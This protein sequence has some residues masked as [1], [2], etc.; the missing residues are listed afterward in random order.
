MKKNYIAFNDDAFVTQLKT[1]KATAP[2]YTADLDLT[3]AELAGQAADC[4]AFEYNVTAQS[5][6]RNAALQSTAFKNSSRMGID[7]GAVA[8]PVASVLPT[9]VPSV[10]AG[11]EARFRALV[12]RIK[13]HPN[14]TQAIGEA[15]GIEG[16]LVSSPD[17]T[18]LAP[19]IT[20]TATGSAV[21]VGW[22]FGG[23]GSFL[24]LCEIEVDRADGKG[25]VM[26]TFDSTP[27]YTDTTPYPVAATQW[28]YRAIFRVGDHR[29][30]QWS[31]PATA[32]V[33]A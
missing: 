29:V 1:F 33:G 17:L 16:D 6:T 25:F 24:D 12:Q 4:N 10:A 31:A 13:A 21:Q 15:L 20:A 7:A 26:L 14:Y 2:T 3:V 28:T 9:V 11:I 5:I 23:N 22:G 32:M 8:A 27:N 18:A 19:T 30:G